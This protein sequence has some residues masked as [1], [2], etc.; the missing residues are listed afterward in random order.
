MTST[1]AD[2]SASAY[3]GAVQNYG[4]PLALNDCTVSGNSATDYGGGMDNEGSG[5]LT[6][7][8]CTIGDNTAGGGGGLWNEGSTATLTDTIVAG[9]NT[10]TL[11]NVDASASDVSGNQANLVTGTYNLI[12]TGGSGGITDGTGGNIVLTSLNV[13]G[14]A[15]LGNYGGPT[16]TMALLAGSPAIGAGQVVGGIIAD[17][18]G[19]PLDSPPDIGAFQSQ[20]F[21]L[22]PVAGS[23]PQAAATG[24]AFANSLAVVVAAKNPVEPVAGG[25]VKFA[26]TPASSGASASL[27]SVVA[28]IT[29]NRVAEVT[30]TANSTDGSYIAAA[31]AVGAAAPAGFSLEN[32]PGYVFS[33]LQSQSI[34]YG[35][36]SVT[37]R[38]DP[39]Q[40]SPGPAANGE[41]RGHAGQRD[42]ER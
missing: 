4:G 6:L 10:S 41:Y 40:R 2:N 11:F 17:Q 18:R 26:V 25:L 13:L 3:G 22:T 38:R 35:T 19:E 23:T 39:G 8:A 12:G 7:T 36:S 34:T 16:Q 28:T 9:N 32:L 15:P 5:T 37:F 27:S 33:G 29:A 20:G 31:T 14:L 30:A 1:F 42:A 21:T 24:V